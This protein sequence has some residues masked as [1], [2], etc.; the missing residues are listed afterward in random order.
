MYQA[1]LSLALALLVV[2]ASVAGQTGFQSGVD[3][4]TL[5]VCVKDQR[6][7][8][9]AGLKA[10]DL[11]V[12][13]NAVRQNVVWFSAEG[14]VPLAL[15]LLVDNSQSMRGGPL[16][17]AG[18]AAAELIASLRPDD[19]VEVM[20]FSDHATLRYPL[21][22]DHDQ[23]K[24]ALEG[25]SAVGPTA[26]YEALLK[27]LDNQE[28]ARRGRAD[29]YREAIVVLS[30]G[31]NTAGHV[32]FDEVL[33]EARHSGVLVYTVS[34]PQPEDLHTG[35]PPWPMAQLALDTG[36]EAVAVRRAEDL[37]QIYRAIAEDVLHL[38]RVAYVP[39]PLAS[40][41][42]WHQIQVHVPT[43]AVV[44]RTRSGYYAP[45]RPQSK[46]QAAN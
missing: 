39:S 32:P 45:Y 23:A 26:L 42:T 6:G 43:K 12:F 14:L 34:Q 16:E 18:A 1:R 21:G 36:G 40:D 33:D 37:A 4:V 5:D 41:G 3:L 8:P 2:A 46:P 38:Y 35:A 13:D 44:V 10:E 7:H 27:A 9:I 25:M 11:S 15:T 24:R 28:R 31:K 30:D 19:L 29:D 22:A 17:R 20:S